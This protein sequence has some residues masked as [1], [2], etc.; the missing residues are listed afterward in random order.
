MAGR[1]IK[2]GK[3]SKIFLSSMDY[4]QTFDPRNQLTKFFC[5]ADTNVSRVSDAALKTRFPV[6][7]AIEIWRGKFSCN[8]EKLGAFFSCRKGL[9]FKTKKH[10]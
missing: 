6:A 4:S 2:P 9:N 7:F 3:A 10:C 8:G 5:F 1:K